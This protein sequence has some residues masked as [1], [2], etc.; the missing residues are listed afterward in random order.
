MVEFHAEAVPDIELAR[1]GDQTLGE[2]GVDTLVAC[3]IR[4]GE[5]GAAHRFAKAH[6]LREMNPENFA[7]RLRRVQVDTTPKAANIPVNSMH[8]EPGPST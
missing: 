5:R 3:F 6:D 1:P 8:S 2:L 4:I 7:D